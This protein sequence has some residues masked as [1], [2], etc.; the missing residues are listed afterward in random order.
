MIDLFSPHGWTRVVEVG[1]QASMF[2]TP[3]IWDPDA[4]P[5]RRN[6]SLYFEAYK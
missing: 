6:E 1:F 4:R 3:E 5:D 2:T